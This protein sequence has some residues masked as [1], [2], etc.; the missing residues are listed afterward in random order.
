MSNGVKHTVASGHV[1]LQVFK[2]SLLLLLQ[3]MFLYG[4]N[5]SPYPSGHFEGEIFEKTNTGISERAIAIDI[6]Y[7]NQGE[8]TINVATLSGQSL[9]RLSV[10]NESDGG[11]RLSLPEPW[12]SKVEL[13]SDSD[14]YVREEEPPVH[15]CFTSD[16]VFLEVLDS[17]K[18]P[19]FTL[20]GD[21]LHHDESF[22]MEVPKAFT[23]VEAIHTARQKNFNSRLEYQRLIQAKH[24]A[25]AA[26]LNLLPH[27]SLSTVLS[28]LA[29][30]AGSLLSTVGDLAPFLLPNR[31]LQAREAAQAARAETDAVVLMQED[32][33][34]EVEGLA[35][36]LIRD[37]E[38]IALYNGLLA[39]ANE[40]LTK[41]KD[42]EQHGQMPEGSADHI[43][44]IVDWM[45]L[46]QSSLTLMIQQDRESIAFA[47]GLHNPKAVTDVSLNDEAIPIVDAKPMNPDELTST[48]I[49][50]ALELSQIDHLVTL[51]SDQKDELYYNWL[52]PMGDPTKEL[53]FSLGE[54]LVVARSRVNELLI[55]KEQIKSVIAQ[56]AAQATDE[57][58]QAL[59]S[60]PLIQKT[61][62]LQERRMRR[63]LSQ[64][65]P[66]TSL[67]TLDIEAVFQDYIN[68]GIRK[69]SL[70]SSFR[71]A[72][73]KIDRLTLQNQYSLIAEQSKP[74]TV[75][76]LPLY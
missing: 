49:G 5:Q 6:S 69:E 4:C 23:L 68:S 70:I 19:L 16:R 35:Y 36:A 33:G 41:V 52:D 40:A 55:R 51:A 38:T 67:N 53:G 42:L 48:A 7:P 34:T 59:E 61:L 37:E 62:D 71:V 29:P 58:N 64:V 75:R 8:G 66:G 56:K 32:L 45:S 28:N 73:S 30:C 65:Q 47:L 43:E 18:D 31:W 12:N 17:Q 60:Y 21:R 24:T 63:V 76:K 20:S 50:E 46:D 44:A 2:P 22:Q 13:T 27:L 14:C 11:I 25:K 15:F 54:N 3:A 74:E 10:E 57:W 72:R 26:Y 1:G 9:F 39:R